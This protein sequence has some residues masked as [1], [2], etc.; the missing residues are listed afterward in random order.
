MVGLIK[1]VPDGRSAPLSPGMQN[2]PQA[3]NNWYRETLAELF[4]LLGAGKIQPAVAARVPLA[5]A[6]AAH[7]LL[8]RGGHA[9][10]VVLVADDIV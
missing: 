5:N 4:D 1:I 6:A 7:E 10:K 2:Y 9:G 3:H 8:E